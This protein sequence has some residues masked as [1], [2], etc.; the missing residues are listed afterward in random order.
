MFRDDGNFYST[1][2]TDVLH[3][4]HSVHEEFKP[5]HADPARSP[6]LVHLDRIEIV[7]Q[8]SANVLE[9]A[10]LWLQEINP[11]EE[12]QNQIAL[13]IIC[14]LEHVQPRVRLAD[15]FPFFCQFA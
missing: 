14:L 8:K 5:A 1:G 10:V 7:T 2:T 13:D 6:V 12:V 15:G 11:R 3:R 4:E 9:D